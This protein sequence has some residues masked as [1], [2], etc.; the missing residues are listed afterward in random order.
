MTMVSNFSRKVYL[1]LFTSKS[2]FF[3][4]YKLKFNYIIN[5]SFSELIF[6]DCS[7]CDLGEPKEHSEDSRTAL[8]NLVQLNK[9]ETILYRASNPDNGGTIDYY[10]IHGMI[11]VFA[12]I[13]FASTGILI[14]RYFKI[15]WSNN[16]ICGEAAW[17]AAHRFILSIA[18][19]LTIVGF[20]FVLV[21]SQGTWVKSTDEKTH[22]THSITGAIVISFAFFQPFI[23]L[24]R[25]KPDSSYRFIYNYLHGFIGFSALILSI[26]TL[27]CATYFPL[28]KDDR[29]RIL[30]IIWTLWIVLIFIVFEIIQI[31]SR[32][33]KGGQS[34]YSN[35]NASNKTIDEL[36]DSSTTPSVTITLDSNEHKPTSED[37]LKNVLLALHIL[38]AAILAIIFSICIV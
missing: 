10:Q 9:Y 19:I 6:Y 5:N 21:A 1:K 20:L 8:S 24:F 16:K 2:Q 32:T 38:F 26:V 27:F 12:W 11:M 37:K 29:A 28:F 17:F 34:R 15:S 23:A 31:Y 4:Q 3:H 30:I 14:S 36:V 7:M 18:T 33:K 25:C 22:F 13:F 35:I